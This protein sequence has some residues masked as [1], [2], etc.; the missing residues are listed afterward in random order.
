MALLGKGQSFVSPF[1]KH[2]LC[3]DKFHCIAGLQFDWIGFDKTR[4]Y[5]IVFV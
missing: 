2:S 5:A 4:K 3:T 1:R